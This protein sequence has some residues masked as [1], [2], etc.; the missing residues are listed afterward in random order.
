MSSPKRRI[1]SIVAVILLLALCLALLI[2]YVTQMQHAGTQAGSQDP[3]AIAARIRPVA[4]LAVE[5]ANTHKQYLSGEEVYT[6]SCVACHGTGIADAPK[7]GDAAAWKA[8]IGAGY[9]TLLFHA[10]NGIG[11]MPAKGGNPDLDDVE[12]A[13]AV[14]LMAN[15]SGARFGEPVI[16]SAP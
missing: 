13:R 10:I 7:V 3:A 15:Q 16:P 5:D 12:V 1:A 14:V 11:I 2:P 4:E 8:R 6:R 9:D